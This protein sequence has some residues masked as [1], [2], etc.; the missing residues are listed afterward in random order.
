MNIS[1]AWLKDYIALEQSPEEIGK[2]LTQIGLEVGG[3]EEFETVK[4][5][6]KGLV[7]GEVV[8][9]VPHPNSDHLSKTTVN[10]GKA[11]LLDIVCGAPNV[12]A[13]QKVVVATVGTTL[14]HGKR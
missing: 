13:G 6:M 9:C 12:A 10:V 4:G 11:E 14:V 1:Y 2:I 3:I 5:G 7:I 8:T